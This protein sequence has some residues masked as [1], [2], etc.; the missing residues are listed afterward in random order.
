MD[1]IHIHPSKEALAWKGPM[2]RLSI[3]RASAIAASCCFGVWVDRC[4]SSLALHLPFGLF[5]IITPNFSFCLEVHKTC[6][7]L[8]CLSHIRSCCCRKDLCTMY[9][10]FAVSF[11]YKYF[12]IYSFFSTAVIETGWSQVCMGYGKESECSYLTRIE[13]NHINFFLLFGFQRG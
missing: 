11:E 2:K 4:S 6:L 3:L 8:V 1:L 10:F 7:C 12:P 5:L 9:V 13:Q